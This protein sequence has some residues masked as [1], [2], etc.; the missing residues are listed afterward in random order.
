MKRGIVGVLTKIA[1]VGAVL[2]V[3][4]GCAVYAEPGYYGRPYHHGYGH[5]YYGGGYYR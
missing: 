5:G 3:L 4:S 2:G 1:L